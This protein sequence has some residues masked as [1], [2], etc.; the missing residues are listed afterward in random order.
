MG[1]DLLQKIYTK[2]GDVNF[3]RFVPTYRRY[4]EFGIHFY[5]EYGDSG[6]LKGVVAI[7]QSHGV[8]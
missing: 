3:G 8:I 4:I 7:Y 6:F 2:H 1:Q 5:T